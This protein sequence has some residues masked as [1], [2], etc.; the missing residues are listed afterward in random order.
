M[1]V[2]ILSLEIY[3]KFLMISLNKWNQLE[4]YSE[5]AYVYYEFFSC[6]MGLFNCI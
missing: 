4:V 1:Y 3:I 2:I 5:I 6:F